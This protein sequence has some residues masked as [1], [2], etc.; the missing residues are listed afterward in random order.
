MIY[1][2]FG[3]NIKGGYLNSIER[4]DASKLTNGTSDVHWELIEL[5]KGY[6]SVRFGVFVAP[7]NST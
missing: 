4:L 5:T 6:I 2:F 3:K 7:I 1:T